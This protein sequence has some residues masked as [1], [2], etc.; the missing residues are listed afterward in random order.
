[1]VVK[2]HFHLPAIKFKIFTIKRIQN[3]QKPQDG[4]LYPG[5]LITGCAFGL[6]EDGPITEELISGGL[7]NESLWFTSRCRNFQ[8]SLSKLTDK[9]AREYVHIMGERKTACTKKRLVAFHSL[10]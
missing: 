10:A 2:T 4:G 7:M 8:F 9:W 6:L 3:K 5:E 1:M